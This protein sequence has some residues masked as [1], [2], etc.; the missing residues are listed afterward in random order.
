MGVLDEI[1]VLGQVL[2]RAHVGRRKDLGLLRDL[3]T[4]A[5]AEPAV[6]TVGAV[7][8]LV[9]AVVERDED[10]GARPVQSDERRDLVAAGGAEDAGRRRPDAEDGA[11]GPVVVHDARAV[12]RVPADAELA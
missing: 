3:D 2:R 10:G 7:G 8:E 1:G 12:E 9:D 11:D 5:R 6:D 4:V